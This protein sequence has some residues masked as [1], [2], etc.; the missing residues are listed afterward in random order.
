MG[1]TLKYRS[2]SLSDLK[3]IVHLLY[4]GDFENK[5]ELISEPLDQRYIEAFNRIDKDSNHHMMVTL[6]KNKIVGF[7]HLVI[8][9]ALSF[10]GATRMQIRSVRVAKEYRSQGIGSSMMEEA[11]SYGRKHGVSIFL[12]ATERDNTQAIRFY[13]SLDFI[14][15]QDVTM[16]ALKDPSH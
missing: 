6:L 9:P 15:L 8:M 4:E 5:K 2:A 16:M 1:H 3:E 11:I 7:C 13:Q 10:V 14:P 12:L